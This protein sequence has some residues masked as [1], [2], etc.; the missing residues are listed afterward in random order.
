M[1]SNSQR[2][3]LQTKGVVI[4]RVLLGLLFLSSG[5]G[6]LFM[7]GPENVAGYFGS[8]GLPMAGLLAWLVIILKVGAGGAIVL[9]KRVGAAAAALIV[10]TFLT[11]LIAH[12][13]FADPSQMT[14]AMKNF[15]II[16]GLLYVIAF[17][18]G[19]WSN[20]STVVNSDTN[21]DSA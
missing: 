9:G 1:L 19:S 4:G 18:A 5:L 14:A 7:Q 17:G 2:E 20:K 8:L 12:N 13:F 3:L 21:S 10:F 15:A 16:G 6:M 11:I